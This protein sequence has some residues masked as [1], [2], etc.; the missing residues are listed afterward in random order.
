MSN[1]FG[2]V[3]MLLFISSYDTADALKDV[4]L[5]IKLKTIDL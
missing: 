2:I 5:Y 1:L 4:K 3:A